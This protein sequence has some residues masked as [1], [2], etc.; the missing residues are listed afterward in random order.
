M[1]GGITSIGGPPMMIFVSIHADELD[2]AA[3]RG[4]NGVLRVLLNAAR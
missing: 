3:W 1:M 2:L 4:T